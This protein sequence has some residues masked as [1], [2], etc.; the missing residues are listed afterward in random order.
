MSRVLHIRASVPT[1]FR[2]ALAAALLI[3]LGPA[4]AATAARPVGCHRHWPVV[5]Y[6]PAAARAKARVRLPVACATEI[7]YPTSE[8]TIAATSSGALFFSPAQSEN[9]L[10]RSFDDGASWSLVYP[11]QMQ[12]TSLWNTVDPDVIAD[13]RTGRLF[14]VRATGDLRTTPIL[15]DESPLGWQAPTAFAY[16]HGFQVYSTPDGGR[17]WVTADD[18]NELTGDWEKVYAGPP[19]PGAPRPSGYPDVVYVCANAPFEVSGPGRACYRSL[20]GGRTFALVAYVFPTA[21]SPH[22]D[23][24]ALAGGAGGG[25]GND[26]TFYQ[27]QSCSGGS[28]VAVSRDEAATWSWYPITGAPGSSG[29][30]SPLQLAIDHADNLYALWTSGSSLELAISRDGG[31]RWSRPIPVDVPGVRQVTLPALAA[32][33]AGHIGIVYY[34]STS[35]SAKRLN[36]YL[37][38]TSDALAARPLLIAGVLNDPAHPIFENYG[39]SDTPRA[40]FIGATYDRGGQLWAGLVKQLGPPNASSVVPTTGYVGTFEHVPSRAGRS[41]VDPVDHDGDHDP[42]A[43]SRTRHLCT[44]PD[45]DN[46]PAHGHAGSLSP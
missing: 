27:P 14:W 21:S 6:Y 15:V 9:S 4:Q 10:A 25:V 23:C 29:L 31:K 5:A 32:G 34:G 7:G 1:A 12:Y 43:P 2:L 38:E 18:Q 16:A 45:F 36:A 26:G 22:E 19:A 37:I 24:P 11:P 30:G 8:T 40:D 17:S 33:P 46:H 41:C 39:F 3:L 44:R 13:R 35:S 28:W 42:A 20:D